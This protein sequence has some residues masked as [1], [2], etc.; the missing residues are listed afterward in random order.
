V[1]TTD[2]AYYVVTWR[3]EYARL[4]GAPED[5]AERVVVAIP[6]GGFAQDV[7]DFRRQVKE[8]F[9]DYEFDYQGVAL[10]R[11]EEI[12]DRLFTLEEIDQF[13]ELD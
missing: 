9:L 7:A 10:D 4:V 3:A 8:R 13:V 2:R 1:A 6:Q 12:F 5:S 11:T